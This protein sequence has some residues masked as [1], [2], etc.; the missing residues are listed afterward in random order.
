MLSSTEVPVYEFPLTLE[1]Q[2]NPPMLNR[3]PQAFDL[4]KK[5][6]HFGGIY[7]ILIH[8]NIT[9]QK[10][11][12]EDKFLSKIKTIAPIWFGT[13]EEYGNWWQARDQIRLD[14]INKGQTQIVTISAP[15]EISGLTL[16]VPNNFKYI[17]NNSKLDV[18]QIGTNIVINHLLGKVQL[19][20]KIGKSNYANLRAYFLTHGEFLRSAE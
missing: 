19:L 14:V 2:A 3:L 1:D 4:A 16:N 9:G 10:L 6:S 20:F 18:T 5:I 17:S 7:V 13:L 12:F 8:P 11:K 15:L